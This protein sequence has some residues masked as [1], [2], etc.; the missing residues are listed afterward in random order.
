MGTRMKTTIEVSD[1]LFES[2]KKLAQKKQTTMRALVEDGLR[3]VLG[4]QQTQAKSAFKLADARVHGKS[5]LLGDPRQWR[6][7]EDAG[8]AARVASLRKQTK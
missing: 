5:M 1:A 3:R 8:I 7:E 4:D 2:A 6:D